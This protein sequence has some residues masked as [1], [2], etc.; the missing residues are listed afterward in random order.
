MLFS[1]QSSNHPKMTRKTTSMMNG[2]GT[3]QEHREKNFL[4]VGVAVTMRLVLPAITIP[5]CPYFASSASVHRV[6]T[7]VMWQAVQGVVKLECAAKHAFIVVSIVAA[8]S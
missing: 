2:S 7:D 8:G 3:N 1:D 6:T 5:M 4:V